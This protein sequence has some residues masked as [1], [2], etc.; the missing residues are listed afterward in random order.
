MVAIDWLLAV[1]DYEFNVVPGASQFIFGSNDLTTGG[2]Q[3]AVVVK[4][5]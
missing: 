1:V 5:V 4:R 2:K 3:A